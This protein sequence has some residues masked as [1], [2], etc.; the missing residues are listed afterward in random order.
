MTNLDVAIVK[1][2]QRTSQEG[3]RY[4]FKSK[5]MLLCASLCFSLTLVIRLS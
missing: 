3:V 2:D 4:I 5:L 1:S